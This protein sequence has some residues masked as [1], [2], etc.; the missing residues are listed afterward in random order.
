MLPR[1]I[2]PVRSA[3]QDLDPALVVATIDS[4]PVTA[5][6]VDT[7]II[8]QLGQLKERFQV[9]QFDLRKQALDAVVITR[10]VDAEAKKD[11]TDRGGGG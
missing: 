10:L 9:Q 4:Q 2:A 1:V 6:D 7:M 3:Q 5:K 8:P 11:G